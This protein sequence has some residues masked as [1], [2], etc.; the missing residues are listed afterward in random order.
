MAFR[1]WPFVTVPFAGSLV[2]AYFQTI[3]ISSC[4]LFSECHKFDDQFAK[5]HSLAKLV[6]LSRSVYMYE[7]SLQNALVGMHGVHMPVSN[8]VLRQGLAECSAI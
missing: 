4:H 7:M 8:V 3:E 1:K 6:K 2:A 5:L